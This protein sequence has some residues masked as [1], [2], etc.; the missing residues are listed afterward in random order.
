VPRLSWAIKW[1]AEDL[2]GTYSLTSI[3]EQQQPL[4]QMVNAREVSNAVC[5]LGSNDASGITGAV[6]CVDGAASAAI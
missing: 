5:F 1:I 4:G 3:I 6:L 2:G